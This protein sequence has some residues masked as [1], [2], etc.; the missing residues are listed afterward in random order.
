MFVMSRISRKSNPGAETAAC[1]E[2]H[3]EAT[4]GGPWSLETPKQSRG[5]AHAHKCPRYSQHSYSQ[6]AILQ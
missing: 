5:D 4:Q 6:H 1:S 3:P 2:S